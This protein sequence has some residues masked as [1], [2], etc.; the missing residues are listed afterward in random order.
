MGADEL[1]LIRLFVQ[2]ILANR[3][4]RILLKVGFHIEKYSLHV[5]IRLLDFK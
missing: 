1:V 2:Q 5:V 4:A 3:E